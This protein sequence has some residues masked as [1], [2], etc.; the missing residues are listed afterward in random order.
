MPVAGVNTT[1]QAVRLG[2]A[3]YF[4]GTEVVDDRSWQ[5][6]PLTTYGLGAVKAY[7]AKGIPDSDY[8]ANMNPGRAMGAIAQIQLEH[9]H[10]WRTAFGGATA[11][12]VATGWKQ[13]DFTV[14][15]HL[16]HLAE[17]P[18]V[19][20]AELDL[21]TLI[22]QIIQLIEADR[23]LGGCVV[24]AGE[25]VFGI[26]SGIPAVPAVEARGRSRTYAYVT[27]QVVTEEQA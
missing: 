23:T 16:F 25:G 12:N 6:G 27:F 20:D 13:E 5:N 2:M 3:E 22:E 21:E 17:Q 4:G 9:S 7:I 18:H 11:Q 24:Q 10:R 14:T 19:E 8:V 26:D 1:R 15:L